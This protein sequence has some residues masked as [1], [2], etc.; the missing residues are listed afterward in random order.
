MG[1]GFSRALDS[2]AN[3]IESHIIDTKR[4]D[5]V[6]R[7]TALGV[8]FID[9]HGHGITI[10]FFMPRNHFYDRSLK[11]DFRGLVWDYEQDGCPWIVGKMISL[12]PEAVH[13]VLR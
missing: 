1:I 10:S 9:S 11:V 7:Q 2:R 3:M 12:F 13:I 6:M 5:W 8:K 4:D